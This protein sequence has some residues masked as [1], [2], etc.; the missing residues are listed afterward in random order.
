MRGSRN[1]KLIECTIIERKALQLL[2]DKNC[3]VLE[4]A[5]VLKR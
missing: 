4:R 3:H 1:L 2:D 5:D